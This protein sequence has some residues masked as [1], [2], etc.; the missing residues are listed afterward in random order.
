MN[1]PA[2][3]DN[4]RVVLV[5]TRNP[6]NIGAA[7]RA[8]SNFGCTHLRLVNPYDPAYREAVSAVGAAPV[9]ASAEQFS[10]VAEAVADCALVVGTTA[11]GRREL[12]HS[13]CTLEAGAR[14][15][16]QHL[17]LQHTRREQP[18]NAKLTRTEV[19]RKKIESMR[20]GRGKT[21]SGAHAA[22]KPTPDRVAVL[23]G[24][25]KTG[26][27]NEDLS[28]CHWLLRIPTREE[29]R[30]MNLG[31]AVAVCLYELVR[32]AKAAA[33][34]KRALEKATPATA[35]ELERFT[36]VLSEA[37]SSSGFLDRRTVA[38]ADERIRRLVRRLN[39]PSRDADMWTGIMRQ[40]V[41]KLH[42]MEKPQ[43]SA[44]TG[45]R[46]HRTT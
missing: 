37:L 12:H 32:D 9:L 13:L 26:L 22:K 21:A 39:L 8:M 35:G 29:H 6:L 24:S 25:E 46:R 17:A 14:I 40:I 41:W 4:L 34:F 44:H 16:L 11:A 15:I 23:F 2:L 19:A 33:K 36:A 38:D 42:A 3:L 27:S 10:T 20:A 45:G 5:A 31:Q 18:A 28:H 1:S 7:A 30:S 43:P